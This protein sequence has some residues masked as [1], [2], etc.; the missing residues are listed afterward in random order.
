MTMKHFDVF[1]H[2]VLSSY[3]REYA[4]ATIL[5]QEEKLYLPVKQYVPQR[6]PVNTANVPAVTII[7]AAAIG[8]PKEVYEPVW[9]AL[10]EQSSAL[11]FNIGSIWIAD[12]VNIAQGERLNHGKLGEDPSWMDHS[13]DLM[14]MIN[15]FRDQMPRP[16]IG[17]GHSA[18]GAQIANIAFM[19]PR[20]L[21]SLIFLDP[22]ILKTP[23]T[24]FREHPVFHK[25]IL[26]RP[27]SWPSRAKA[28]ASIA[29]FPNYM[30]WHPRSLQRF[31]EH[32][33]VELTEANS[34][35]EDSSKERPVA[36]TT[37]VAQEIHYMG[38]RSLT[39]RLADGTLITN[40]EE[41]PDLD[42]IDAERDDPLYRHEMRA[43]WDRLPELR[44]SAKFILGGKS[45]VPLH[46]LQ[47]GAQRCGTGR[48]GSGGAQKGRV[49]QVVLKKG[50]HFFPMELVDDTA[51]ECATWISEEVH[52]WVKQEQKFR[53]GIER[54]LQNGDRIGE[55]L[56]PWMREVMASCAAIGKV[57]AAQAAKSKI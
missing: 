6:G 46:E 47:E 20:L 36:L 18:G 29:K 14:Q 11:G 30:T 51:K 44:P 25:F 26:G 23:P 33:L 12:P 10:Y 39:Q 42:P 13:R 38:R 16:L 32:G 53:E 37:S 31:F 2:K 24:P 57:K 21:S 28:E 8:P 41:T 22:A 3:V 15:Q 17:I 50:S 55:E 5:N 35:L 49:C 9:E 34:Q 45:Y 54:R 48:S 52:R 4:G 56:A 40:Y 27:A 7:A 43:T 19:H 1:E